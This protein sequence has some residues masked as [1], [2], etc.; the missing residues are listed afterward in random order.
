M[1]GLRHGSV[2]NL[3]KE[4][5]GGESETLSVFLVRVVCSLCTVAALDPC[6]ISLQLPGIRFWGLGWDRDVHVVIGG[7]QV[8]GLN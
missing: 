2:Q 6:L 7:G 1:L 4:G 3:E 5:G 8:L